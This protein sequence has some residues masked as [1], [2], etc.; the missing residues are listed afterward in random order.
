MVGELSSSSK[1]NLSL[2]SDELEEENVEG[3]IEDRCSTWTQLA[4]N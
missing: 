3:D 2:E 4:M 1:A